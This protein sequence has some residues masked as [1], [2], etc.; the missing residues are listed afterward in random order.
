MVFEY[1][2]ETEA[3]M[4]IVLDSHKRL[5]EQRFMVMTLAIWLIS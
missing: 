1:Q 4:S 3:E 5:V 2:N